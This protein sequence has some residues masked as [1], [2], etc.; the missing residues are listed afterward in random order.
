MERIHSS[1]AKTR[2][3]CCARRGGFFFLRRNPYGFPSSQ[4]VGEHSQ[5]PHAELQAE[6]IEMQKKVKLLDV[7]DFIRETEFGK[8]NC[9]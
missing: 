4:R 8:E 9:H 2:T 5:N 7:S 1:L 3:N 6:V